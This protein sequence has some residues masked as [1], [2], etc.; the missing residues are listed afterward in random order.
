MQRILV[1]KLGALGD[2]ILAASAFAAIR[3]ARPEAEITLLTTAPFA[4]L[5]R[6][7][8]WFDRV[9]TDPRAPWWNLTASL[10]LARRL[11]GYD[12]VYDLQTSRRSTLYFRLAGRPPWSGIAR[13]S[14]HRD[15]NPERNRMHTIERQRAQLAAAGIREFPGPGFAWLAAAGKRFA[16]E[17]PYA[18]LV[19][20]AAAH[21]PAKR[22]P[23]ERFAALARRLVS[24]GMTPVLI[25]GGAERGLGPAIRTLAPGAVDLIGMTDLLDLG[26]LAANAALA[27]GN[28]T[29]PMHVAAAL[30][31]P[32]LVLF[33]AASDPAL[34][35]PRGPDGALIRVL[36]AENL[37]D[38]PLARVAAALP[39]PHRRE[40]AEERAL[41]CPPSR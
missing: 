29:G 31:C 16:L 37:A 9:A 6:R 3:C 30:G 14:S 1:I 18:L 27:V 28:D 5:A 19:P 11:R 12:C 32:S 34:T 38:L 20:G 39:C 22:W 41:P 24:G 25:G 15:A 2:F 36:R 33:S 21:R 26:G 23:P 7:A 40:R 17:H 8:P 35:A 13:G 4:G 10:G